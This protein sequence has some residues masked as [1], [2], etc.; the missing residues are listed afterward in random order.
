[1]SEIDQLRQGLLVDPDAFC[2]S[3]IQ[4]R[5]RL[6]YARAC[7]LRDEAIQVG[8]VARLHRLTA[9]G[10]SEYAYAQPGRERSDALEWFTDQR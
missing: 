1:M 9:Q 10:Q 3:W 5:L 7:T 6:G 4:R 8:M 2:V